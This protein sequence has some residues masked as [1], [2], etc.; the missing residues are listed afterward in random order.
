MK[1]I[2]YLSALAV[3]VLAACVAGAEHGND[4]EHAPP[5][6]RAACA[7]PFPDARQPL[8]CVDDPG[9]RLVRDTCGACTCR[10]GPRRGPR[11]RLPRP[12]CILLPRPLRRAVCRQLLRTVPPLPMR[13]R[14]LR[15]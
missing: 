1:P 7:A 2:A 3:L 6:L 4:K 8:V 14:Q 13:V 5:T 11:S 10:G 12:A 9:C 15:G